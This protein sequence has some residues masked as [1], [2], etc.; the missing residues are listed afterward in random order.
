MKQKLEERLC[1]I[2]DKINLHGI[3]QIQ[4]FHKKFNSNKSPQVEYSY[5]PG[6]CH[7]IFPAAPGY[8]MGVYW[9]VSSGVKQLELVYSVESGG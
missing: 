3:F 8:C 4:N 6:G 5:I 9:F 7:I 2:S 1:I